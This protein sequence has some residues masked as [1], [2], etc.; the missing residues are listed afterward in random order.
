[1]ID[2]SWSGTNTDKVYPVSLLIEAFDRM[3]VFQQ[4]IACI[5]HCNINI[6]EVKTKLIS[7]EGKMQAN[8]VLDIHNINHYKQLKQSLNELSDIVSIVRIKR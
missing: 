6:R 8:L 5:A 2:V 3:G 7:S 4:I 1:M